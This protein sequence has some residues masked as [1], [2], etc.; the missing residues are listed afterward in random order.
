MPARLIARGRHHPGAFNAKTY[1]TS[2]S[3]AEQNKLFTIAGAQAIR[4]GSSISSVVN[5]RR[6]MYTTTAYGRTVRATRDATTRRG[7]FYRSER[8]M[9]IARGRVPV[10]GRG[11]RL[12]A[13]RLLP[14]E[15][16]E[17]AAG[18]RDEAIRMLRRFGYIG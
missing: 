6:G 18:N 9:A 15:I 11:F 17:L 13:P 8:A 4:D 3:R 5:A 12:R 1:F 10:S 7:A 16:Y 2:L 14:E